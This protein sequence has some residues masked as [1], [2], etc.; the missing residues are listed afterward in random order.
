[1][2]LNAVRGAI[3]SP[4]TPERLKKGLIKKYGKQ[5]GLSE[6]KCPASYP[7]T[8]KK[9]KAKAKK[10]KSNPPEFIKKYIQD[11][12]RVVKELTIKDMFPSMD[13]S[14]M[15]EIELN[16][17]VE[18]LFDVN[19]RKA[20]NNMEHHKR[21]YK[22]KKKKKKNPDVCPAKENASYYLGIS[23]DMSSMGMIFTSKEKP[24]KTKYPQFKSVVGSFDSMK[25]LSSYANKMGIKIMNAPKGWHLRKA[26]SHK[27]M[28]K[29]YQ[30][31]GVES[32]Q[33]W[34]G[35]AEHAHDESARYYLDG[36]NNKVKNPVSMI[37]NPRLAKTKDAYEDYLNDIYTP[38]EA[39]KTGAYMKQARRLLARGFYGSALRKY[40]P[41]AF[42][43]GFNEWIMK[44]PIENSL[45][46]FT[47]YSKKDR[48][49]HD[50]ELRSLFNRMEEIRKAPLRDRQ[51]AC[52]S[53]LEYSKNDPELVAERIG[54]LLN[55]TYGYAE[56]YLANRDL[57]HGMKSKRFN[58]NA[59]LYNLIAMIEWQ[60]PYANKVY[61]K[62][63]NREQKDLNE[64]ISKEL[65]AYV[66]YASGGIE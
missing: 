23:K 8:F 53:L 31:E 16:K 60:C 30:K 66:E 32:A 17:H 14:G 59:A 1:M 39:M 34:H 48:P 45:Q 33:Y 55:G 37:E 2:N 65:D 18:T 25:D 63:S 11:S 6:N 51:E 4:K 22:L 13:V 5:L 56:G 50:R 27:K 28:R 57:E 43:V 61:N 52:D 9:I 7:K 38:D 3:N 10:A 15:A 40:D 44:N 49:Y 46:Y 21:T 24:S 35:G 64:A 20:Y 29:Q 19:P 47:D 62:L 58:L 12:P 26:G 54:W 42:E 41:I 36:F